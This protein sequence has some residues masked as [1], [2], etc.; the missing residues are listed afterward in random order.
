M[1]AGAALAAIDPTTI[2]V[3][4]NGVKTVSYTLSGSNPEI[5][6]FEVHTNGV[7]ASGAAK[8][9]VG[10]VF[11]K[12]EPG[13]H[14]FVWRAEKALPEQVYATGDFAIKLKTWPLNCP[15]DYMILDAHD[16]TARYYRFETDL[17]RPVTDTVYTASGVVP[18]R[19]ISVGL[20]RHVRKIST[21]EYPTVVTEDFY[22]S[23]FPVTEGHLSWLQGETSCNSLPK[24]NSWTGWRGSNLAYPTKG[25]VVSNITEWTGIAFDLP[26]EAQW[27]LAARAGDFEH[28]LTSGETLDTA[29]YT[30]VDRQ[31]KS[32]NKVRHYPQLDDIAWYAGNMP[33]DANGAFVVPRVGLKKPNRW[34]I[35]DL[36]GLFWEVCRD[37]WPG[38]NTCPDYSTA[39]VYDPCAPAQTFAEGGFGSG[40]YAYRG[41][42][43]N[44]ADGSYCTLARR[45]GCRP[46]YSNDRYTACDVGGNAARLGARLV[47]PAK[48]VW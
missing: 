47:C 7:L 8:F 33:V 38:R 18:F 22:F 29:A 36:L 40:W 31:L 14:S 28:D 24:S 39:G 4:G 34:G 6:T 32:G 43:C 19:K 15:P 48:A 17:P 9:A 42:A 2:V 11:R 21:T 23:V 26:T 37:C 44:L 5:V 45:D 13:A 27:E 3:T 25:G 12:L 16:K 35:Y 20:Q 30:E 46:T 1:S 41:G 10:D